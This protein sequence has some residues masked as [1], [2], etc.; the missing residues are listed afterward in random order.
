ML[1]FEYVFHKNQAYEYNHHLGGMMKQV[2]GQWYL[3]NDSLYTTD[4]QSPEQ[5]R[6]HFVIQ[7]REEHGFKVKKNDQSFIHLIRK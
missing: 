5:L 4:E 3:S 7:A 6:I 2:I 1:N